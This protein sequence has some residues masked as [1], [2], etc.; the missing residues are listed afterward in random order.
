M[1][2]SRLVAVAASLALGVGA[3][4]SLQAL[5]QRYATN[6]VETWIDGALLELRYAGATA[7]ERGAVTFD[8]AT[9]R[10]SIADVAITT[11]GQVPGKLTIAR[12]E[13]TGIAPAQNNRFRADTLSLSGAVFEIGSARVGVERASLD[14]LDMPALTPSGIVGGDASGFVAALRE[15]SMQ[16]AVI[17]SVVIRAQDGDARF[18]VTMRDIGFDGLARGIVQRTRIGSTEASGRSREG[19]PILARAGASVV[20][21]FDLALYTALFVPAG[22]L[23]G[24][25]GTLFAQSRFEGGH[26]ELGQDTRV[27]IG[28]V[29]SRNGRLKPPRTSL[30]ELVGLLQQVDERRGGNQTDPAALRLVA[31]A[32]SDWTDVASV[33]HVEAADFSLQSPEATLRVAR[34]EAHDYGVAVVGRL[35][36]E[37]GTLEAPDVRGEFGLFAITEWDFREFS[38]ALFA[39]M[40]A[41]HS[42]PRPQAFEGRLPRIGAIEVR[43]VALTS[44]DQ[45]RITLGSAAFRM[46]RWLGFVPDMLRLTVSD[47]D[48]PDEALRNVR[49]PRPRDLGYDKVGMNGDVHIRIDEQARTATL[50]PGRVALTDVGA[51]AVE[52]RLGNVESRRFGFDG[53]TDP[54]ALLQSTSVERLALRIENAG[55]IE[56]FVTWQARQ[57]NVPPDQLRQQLAMGLVPIPEVL[58]QDERQKARARAA[59]QAFTANPRS[60]TVVLTPRAPMTLAD[61]AAASANGPPL[62]LLPRLNI[63]VSAN[64]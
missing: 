29:T 6:V 48:V 23:A 47:L 22:P 5:A 61:I 36:L 53:L 26:F 9:G 21:A 31:N 46:G 35:A 20:E 59:I 12:I 38:R 64:D 45:G 7:V 14:R 17:P 42:T 49:P 3:L 28:P 8:P 60:I 58:I 57:Q 4:A 30:V 2:R 52:L 51:V 62:A 40:G 32:M 24:Q 1:P 18:E 41:G 11:G 37:R 15:A 39:E 13:G 56:R 33:E 54:A 43:D 50:A 10:L 27:S 63:E 25:Q 19:L 44:A 34:F 16:R 55:F